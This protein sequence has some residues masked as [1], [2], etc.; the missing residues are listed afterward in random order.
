MNDRHTIVVVGAG[1]V[2]QVYAGRLAA[3][4]HDV[5]LLARGRTLDTLR[6]HGVRL[7]TG[8]EPSTPPVTVAADAAELPKVVDTA[9]LAV[10][11]DQVASALPLLEQV[12]ARTVVT[13]VNLAG[14]VSP[15]LDRLGPERT[16]L[17]FS[18][19]G[20]L[21]GP[22][23]VTYHEVKQQPT[24]IGRAGRLEEPVVADL[25]GAG[26][27]VD[28]VDEPVAWLATHAVFVVGVGAAILKAGGSVA[29]G[30]DRRLTA[31]MITAVRDGFGA[32]ASRGTEVTPTPQ[33]IIFTR[34][35]KLISVPYWGRQLRG[36]L[37]TLALEPHVTA[38]R[39]TEFRYLVAQTRELTGNSEVLSAYLTAAG[40][41]PQESA[42]GAVNPGD[43]R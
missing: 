15:V 37:G 35:P 42:P 38:T 14:D 21:R 17:G 18:G 10:R 40:F 4:G 11:G 22:E 6:E 9:Y 8:Q 12:P 24:T 1:V 3:S 2:G 16:V 28:V 19:I 13:L 23:G 27:T 43:G 30:S 29:L 5:H 20:G 31:Q 39:D 36:E 32:L 7:R 25:R 33:R 34:V 41:P 26:L